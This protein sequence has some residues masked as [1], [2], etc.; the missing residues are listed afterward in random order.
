[1]LY[2]NAQ[3]HDKKFGFQDYINRAGG[4][5]AN[6]DKS[7]VLFFRRDGSIDNVRSSR[8]TFSRSRSVNAG[9]EIVVLPK[10]DVKSLQLAKDISQIVYQIAIATRVAVDF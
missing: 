10:A 3:L 9:D 5:T 6:A 7:N 8:S 2:P 1:M 4:Y